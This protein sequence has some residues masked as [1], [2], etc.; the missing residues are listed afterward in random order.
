MLASGPRRLLPVALAL[1]LLLVAGGAAGGTQRRDAT[2][3]ELLFVLNARSGTLRAL[4]GDRYLL[5]LK[6]VSRQT[7]A[8]A[9]RPQRLTD[10]L[11]TSSFFARFWKPGS[12]FVKDPPNAAL[13]VVDGETDG[14][15]VVLELRRPH[16][17]GPTLTFVTRRLTPSAGLAHYAKRVD[18]SPPASF[19][20]ASLFIDSL[21]P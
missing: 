13:D 21:V 6:G 15:A 4:G 20:D 5:T 1:T 14:D 11:L 2:R 10:N 7:V 8:F 17:S 19:G 12:S 9:D 18:P 16:L 3:P